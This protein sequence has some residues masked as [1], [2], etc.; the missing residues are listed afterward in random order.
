MFGPPAGDVLGPG[1]DPIV[2]RSPKSR[3]FISDNGPSGPSG[4]SRR[5]NGT[6]NPGYETPSPVVVPSGRCKLQS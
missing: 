5:L 3:R 4:R 1:A 2:L 6:L